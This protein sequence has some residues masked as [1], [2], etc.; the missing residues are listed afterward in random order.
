MGSGRVQHLAVKVGVVQRARRLAGHDG[1]ES[2]RI[3]VAGEQQFHPVS[4]Q[5]HVP[6]T[7]IVLLWPAP[8]LAPIPLPVTLSTAFEPGANSVGCQPAVKLPLGIIA[9]PLHE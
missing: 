5:A 7:C 6:R 3:R 2:L 8:E 9:V 1:G 4:Q